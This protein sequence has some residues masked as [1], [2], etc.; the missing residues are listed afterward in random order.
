MLLLEIRIPSRQNYML[1]ATTKV[2]RLEFCMS[3]ILRL[4][5]GDSFGIEL[6]RR[7]QDQIRAFPHFQFYDHHR[8][9][10]LAGQWVCAGGL[11]FNA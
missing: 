7:Q 6:L 11:L 1:T 3:D 4:I 2:L 9:E 8:S 5:F 10:I